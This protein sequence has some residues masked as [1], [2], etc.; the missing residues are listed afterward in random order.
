VWGIGR[1]YGHTGG[2][3]TT[4]ADVIWMLDVMAALDI[5]PVIAGGWGVDALAGAPT[6][7]HRD[8]DVLVPEPGVAPL[9]AALSRHSFVV[10]VDQRPVRIELSDRTNDR[11]IDIHPAHDDGSGGYWQH[12]F[13]S[14]RFTTPADTITVGVIG[15]RTVRCFTVAKQLDVHAGYEPAARDI[16]D[17]EVLR[18]LR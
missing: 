12:G 16:A 3:P 7:E 5:E 15:G 4:E 9:L 6:R 18:G 11:H 17:I 13:G 8:L 10:T 1:P 14:D 2:V